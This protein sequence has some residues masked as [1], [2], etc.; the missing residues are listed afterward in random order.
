MSTP[1][2]GTMQ[3]KSFPTIVAGSAATVL[4]LNGLAFAQQPPQQQQQQPQQGQTQQLSNRDVRQFMTQ[5]ERDINQMM[6]T[7]NTSRLRQWTQSHVADNA[8][9]S[10]TRSIV[11]EGQS[12]LFAAATITKQDLLRL[13]HFALSSMPELLGSPQ[14]YRLNIQVVNIQ[15][16]GDS[17]ALVKSHISESRTLGGGRGEFGGRTGQGEFGGRMGQ[18][19]QQ[20]TTGQGQE[21]QGDEFAEEEG[22]QQ[23]FGRGGQ[24]RGA[25]RGQQAG[26]QLETHA[27]CSHLVEQNRSS[28]R[29]QIA[30]GICEAETDTQF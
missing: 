23:S 29:V 24:Q 20:F 11:G 2:R 3:M 18:R 19:E 26:L 6:Q 1:L 17:A 27:T 5:I 12:K 15:P 8:V 10:G 25:Q 7:G 22:T 21:S 4:M 28:G 13:Q 30:M 14:E 16:V 9:F